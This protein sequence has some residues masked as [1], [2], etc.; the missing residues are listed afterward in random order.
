MARTTVSVC[1]AQLWARYYG[2]VRG[3]GEA[4]GPTYD[5]P[6]WYEWPENEPVP[7]SEKRRHYAALLLAS[8]SPQGEGAK[9]LSSLKAAATVPLAGVHVPDADHK[10]C[11]RFE[12]SH[13]LPPTQK[14]LV[15]VA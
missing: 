4:L 1:S 3:D 5:R 9:A 12:R 8:R 13:R 10:Q 2:R 15:L 11:R 6:I 14:L 7:K